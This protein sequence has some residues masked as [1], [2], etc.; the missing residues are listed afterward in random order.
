MALTKNALWVAVSSTLAAVCLWTAIMNHEATS[1][2]ETDA[3][4][5]AIIDITNTAA[6]KVREQDE[7]GQAFVD[8]LAS[9]ISDLNGLKDYC[10]GLEANFPDAYGTPR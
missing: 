7:A 10:D 6:D 8:A 9:D 4:K 1:T 3:V 5:D 2:V